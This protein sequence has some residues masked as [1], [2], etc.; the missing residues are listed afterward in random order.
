MISDQQTERILLS[1]ANEDYV[2]LYELIWEL[3]AKFPETTLAEKYGAAERA[4]RKLLD[5]GWLSLYRTDPGWKSFRE[6]DRTFAEEELSDPTSWYP[7]K[8]SASEVEGVCIVLAAT[9]AGER[10]YHGG[11]AG[12][13][14]SGRFPR[15]P[16]RRS[17]QNAPSTHFGE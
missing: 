3:N 13:S 8:H 15:R 7:V 16:S 11:A 17:S 10:A 9:E 4:A 5:L 12:E 6:L 2:G 1:S 14:G